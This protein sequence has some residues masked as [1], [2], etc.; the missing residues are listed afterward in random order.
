MS[1]FDSLIDR[2]LAHEGGYVNDPRDPGGETQW[3]ISKRQYPQLNIRSLTRAQAIEIYR[4]DYWQRVQGDKL[5]AAAAF[6]VMDAAV[7]HGVGTAI[8]WLQRAVGVADDG[9]IGPRTLAAVAVA[10]AA[11]LVLLFNAERLEFYAKLSTFDA[12]G[13]GW[14]RR[15]AGNL[16]LAAVDN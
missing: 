14:T 15:V 6:Q 4:R 5:P 11:D 2:V 10:P 1:Q 12:F 13:K 9:V 7:N 3:G 8:R 16:R